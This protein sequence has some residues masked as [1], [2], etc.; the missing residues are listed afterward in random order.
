MQSN[1]SAGQLSPPTTNTEAISHLFVEIDYLKRLIPMIES[2]A[3]AASNKQ[4]LPYIPQQLVT[5]LATSSNNIIHLISESTPGSI[6]NTGPLPPASI[7]YTSGPGSVHSPRRQRAKLEEITQ[8]Q[9]NRLFNTVF[10]SPGQDSS[11][12]LYLRVVGFTQKQLVVQPVPST[13]NGDID[14]RWLANNPI[15]GIVTKSHPGERARLSDDGTQIIFRSRKFTPLTSSLPATQR[16]V[17]TE[18]KTPPP[19]EEY[20]EDTEVGDDSLPVPPTSSATASAA[21]NSASQLAAIA[22]AKAAADALAKQRAMNKPPPPQA[23][24]VQMQKRM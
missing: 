3:R 24:P 4:P 15:N 6:R 7:G 9:Q 23:R 19:E 1:N 14:R 21:P 11:L 16:P 8:D 2:F 5:S 22:S 17:D 20:Y 12:P 10:V 13:N 18:P